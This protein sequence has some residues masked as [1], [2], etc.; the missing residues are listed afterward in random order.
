V[1]RRL[2]VA[3]NRV[4]VF[5]RRDSPAI[6]DVVEWR[7]GARV[8]HVPAGP[9]AEVAKEDLLP[10]MPA[11][12]DWMLGHLERQARPYDLAHANFWTS[13]LVAADLKE[14]TGIPFV[15]TFHALGRVR[16]QF[17]GE[18]D[19]FP[20]QRFEIEE[21]IVR[22]AD[23]VIAECPQDAR[24]LVELYGAVPE[25]LRVVPCGYDPAEFSPVDQ[26]AARARLGVDPGE[27]LILQLGRLVPRKGVDTVIEAVAVL[28]DRH[29]MRVR[30]L[31]VG[32]AARRPDPRSDPELARLMAIV[33]RLGLEDQVTFLGRRDRDELRD[34]YGAADLFVST[35]WYEP[36]GITPVEAMA[37][38]V[39]VIGSN[40][41][42]IKFSV[43]DGETGYLVPPRNPVA[44]A[45]R[46]AAACAR[47][48]VLATLGRNAARRAAA[49]FTWDRVAGQ[50]E[51]V[52]DEVLETRAETPAPSP[53]VWRDAS[54]D[55]GRRAA[56]RA[57]GYEPVAVA[58]R[59]VGTPPARSGGS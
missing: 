44:L 32:G 15:V 41:G 6:A 47:P 20:D 37:C 19:R 33:E 23:L 12:R 28:R 45:D 27:R 54:P 59:A 55:A 56:A 48:E 5:T 29:A 14:R 21:R 4:D 36:F 46:I 10:L 50:I 51:A 34:L 58:G 31:V 49:Q 3:G 13:G 9:P 38:G 35:P 26:A 16:R 24:D 11:F 39:P 8:Y 25:R 22:E 40:V 7:P 52:Y 17:Q 18:A 57:A 53:A 42:G 43:V 1:S 30:L 2:A